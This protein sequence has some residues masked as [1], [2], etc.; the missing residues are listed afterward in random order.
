MF[1]AS[2]DS[3]PN[4]LARTSKNSNLGVVWAN[5]PCC[6]ALGLGTNSSLILINLLKVAG[7]ICLPTRPWGTPAT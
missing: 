4:C 6:A 2:A 3:N 5:I 7:V 1:K